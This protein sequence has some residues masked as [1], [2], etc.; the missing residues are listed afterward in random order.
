MPTAFKRFSCDE[1]KN[2][3]FVIVFVAPTSVFKT[4]LTHFIEGRLELNLVELSSI[5]NDTL[6]SVIVESKILTKSN[7]I[8]TLRQHIPTREGEFSLVCPGRQLT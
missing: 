6:F 2:P 8:K 3:V 7:S 5:L 1:G 4:M